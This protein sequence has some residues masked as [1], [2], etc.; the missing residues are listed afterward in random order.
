MADNGSKKGFSF[1]GAQYEYQSPRRENVSAKTPI[2][3]IELTLGEALKLALALEEC[4]RKVNR[5][6]MS[7]TVGKR[8]RVGLAIHFG[9]KRI[10]TYEG[11]AKKGSAQPDAWVPHRLR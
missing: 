10:A 11:K 2:L 6:K 9:P 8:A 7:T 1:G 5:Y 4:C 3:N